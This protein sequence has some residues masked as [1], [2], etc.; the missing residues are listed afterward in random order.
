M[1]LPSDMDGDVSYDGRRG[2]RGPHFMT[3][4]IR[5]LGV[6]LRYSRPL[7]GSHILHSSQLILSLSYTLM[8]NERPIPFPAI[9]FFAET[10]GP[11]L[12][13]PPEFAQDT[14][15][16]KRGRPKGSKNKKSSGAIIRVDTSQLADTSTKPPVGRPCG[17]GHKV[18]AKVTYVPGLHV[19]MVLTPAQTGPVACTNP[20]LA[21]PS[22]AN[23]PVRDMSGPITSDNSLPASTMMT[24]PHPS[25][26][27]ILGSIPTSSNNDR[28]LMEH[29]LRQS[30][31]GLEDPVTVT[32]C[33]HDLFGD[34]EDEDPFMDV[35]KKKKIIY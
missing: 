21:S 12:V 27:S 13:P 35:T 32:G 28:V 20:N 25:G 18:K 16:H 6:D 8:S 23:L 30:I 31:C 7:C 3:I 15:Q 10:P 29:P 14:M 11:V 19:R 24:H 9:T 2:A 33:P 1:Y 22:Q 34:T 5:R 17:S 26:Q 4:I